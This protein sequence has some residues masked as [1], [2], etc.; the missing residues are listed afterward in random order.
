MKKSVCFLFFALLASLTN[1]Q[2]TL[3]SSSIVLGDQTTLAIAYDTNC[4]SAN[5]LMRD[6]IVVVSQQ[7]DTAIQML[8]SRITSFEPGDHWIHVG[9]DSILLQ[10]RDVDDLDTAIESIRDI[11]DIIHEP[12]HWWDVARWPVG[13]IVLVFVAAAVLYI[14]S[15]VHQHKPI[16]QLPTRPQLP[17][18]EKALQALEQLRRKQLWQQGHVKAYHTELTDIVR[19]YL[20]SRCGFNATERTTDQ[21]CEAFAEWALSQDLGIDKDSLQ[22]QMDEMLRTADMVK[23][24]KSEPL[25]YIHDRSLNQALTLVNALAPKKEESD[26]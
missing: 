25:P 18:H 16:I 22:N 11:A 19:Q 26:E 6:G 7:Y 8:V 5:D 4:P 23:F 17:P 2:I 1:A 10:V 3:D 24:A 14:V 12:L 9:G 21:T 15:R 20:E 13:L